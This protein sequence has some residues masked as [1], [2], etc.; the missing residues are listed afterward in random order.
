[1]VEPGH[2]EHRLPRGHVHV[3]RDL[4][5]I[6]GLA[7]DGLM[8]EFEQAHPVRVCLCDSLEFV[9]DLGKRAVGHAAVGEW[10]A[11]DRN[12]CWRTTATAAALC[13]RGLCDAGDRRSDR[14]EF[15]G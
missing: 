10:R 9:V 8:R 11:G 13:G 3:M 6:D 5:A 2:Q 1:M 15:L 4:D 12:W 14:D 7:E